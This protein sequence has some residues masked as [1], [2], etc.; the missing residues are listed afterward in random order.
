VFTEDS[1]ADTLSKLLGRRRKI[2]FEEFSLVEKFLSNRIIARVHGEVSV[3]ASQGPNRYRPNVVKAIDMAVA[4]FCQSPLASADCPA[5]LNEVLQAIGRMEAARGSRLDAVHASLHLATLETDFVIGFL[6]KRRYVTHNAGLELTQAL[7]RYTGHINQQVSHGYS[8]Y[9]QNNSLPLRTRTRRLLAHR[10]LDRRS[11][12]DLG[13]LADL[14]VRAEWEIPSCAVVIQAA[15]ETNADVHSV[16]RSLQPLE[17]KFLILPSLT[18]ITL[19]GRPTIPDEF[20]DQLAKV[21]GVALVVYCWPVPISQIGNAAS[22]VSRALRLIEGG[23]IAHAPVIACAD[24]RPLLWL[25]ADPVLVEHATKSLLGPILCQ[26]PHNREVLAE[27]LL[28]YLQTR[29]SAPKMAELMDRHVQTIR[30]RM[31][32]L[33]D[34]YGEDLDDPDISLA[35][36]AALRAH[37]IKLAE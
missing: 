10:L 11:H 7:H 17:E 19:I 26:K 28:V 15:L 32:R 33:R 5:H 9:L 22:W 37:I 4:H 20:Y 18:R 36:I 30:K 25:H 6:V 31:K 3:L 27:T 2:D 24:H 16:M 14:A 13:A 35:L 21:K 29:A 12:D 34:L 8:A 23:Q 1:A